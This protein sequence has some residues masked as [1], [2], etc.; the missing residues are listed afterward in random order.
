MS[1]HWNWFASFLVTAAV[2]VSPV[3][4]AS[5]WEQTVAA[6]KK[7]GSVVVS[8]SSSEVLRQV[9]TE[10]E[11]DY[12]GIK[13]AYHSGNLR[14]F[15][16]RV[17]KERE[18][19][20]YNW[21]LRIGGTDAITY[22]WKSAG[23]LDPIKPL[24]AQPE[25]ANESHWIGG[26]DSLFGD[27]ER[28]YVMHFSSSL[29]G[30]V[31]VDRDVIPEKD[32]AS[33]QHL[34]DPR[35][36]GKIVMQDPRTGGSGNQM[37]AALIMKYGDQFAR[38]L[39]SKQ[40]VVISDSKRQMAEWLVRKQYPIALGM[41]TD[42]TIVQFQQQG[43]GKQLKTVSADDALGGDAVILMNKAPHP[44]A[45][46]VYINWLLSKKTQTRLAEVARFNSRRVDV[47]PGAPDLAV[48][49]QRIGQYLAMSNEEALGAKIKAQQISKELLK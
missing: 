33:S 9:L 46:K 49:P 1:K 37:L 41:G 18:V 4:H 43:L 15:G 44:N 22:Q 2:S 7:E 14:D 20:Q 26:I 19:G 31:T 30:G 10:F 35:W 40:N 23:L 24:L 25:V 16:S 34:L 27:K 12:P 3:V 32:F 11:K 48:N 45:A 42:D 29:F 21:D 17:Q 39:L 28:Q 5:D 38:D 8:A 6:A 47:K 13:V 36:K